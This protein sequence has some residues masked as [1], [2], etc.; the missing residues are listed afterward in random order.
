MKLTRQ[1]DDTPR[2]SLL[3]LLSEYRRRNLPVH[4]E[5]Q[6][7]ILKWYVPHSSLTLSQ[8]MCRLDQGAEFM[9]WD[10]D[11][12]FQTANKFSMAQGMQGGDQRTTANIPNQPQNPAAGSATNPIEIGGSTPAM[13]VASLGPSQTPLM[14][15]G[16]LPGQQGHMRQ[17]SFGAGTQ[18]NPQMMQ[19]QQQQ[20]PP[21]PTQNSNGP[22]RRDYDGLDFSSE[23]IPFRDEAQLWTMVV[24][25]NSNGND[26]LSRPMIAGQPVDLFNLF[27]VVH[28]NGGSAKVCTLYYCCLVARLSS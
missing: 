7:V 15:Y 21:M 1:N 12:L 28:K 6:R 24:R 19:Q 4:E 16:Q 10:A 22:A 18:P 11:T 25:M 8:L 13:S 26:N 20:R 17:P 2:Q 3:Y 14:Q 5:L 23:P 9:K 27:L